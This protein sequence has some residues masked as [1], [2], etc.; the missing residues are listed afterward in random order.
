MQS[1]GAAID[2]RR[3][4][5]GVRRM[6]VAAQKLTRVRGFMA[7]DIPQVAEV[8]RRAFKSISGSSPELAAE[9][10]SYFKNVFLYNPWRCGDIQP[11]VYQEDDGSISGFLGVLP[12]RMSLRGQT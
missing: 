11:L 10:E 1:V 5:M 3:I 12:Q 8:H 6:M 7:A 2:C 9:Y 4:P